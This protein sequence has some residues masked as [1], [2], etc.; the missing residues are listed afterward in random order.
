MIFGLFSSVFFLFGKDLDLLWNKFLQLTNDTE[1]IL[2]L[3]PLNHFITT[4]HLWNCL[5]LI[6][7][8]N[9]SLYLIKRARI[10]SGKLI[11][12][13][14]P[15]WKK[16]CWIKDWLLFK[17]LNQTS[18]VWFLFILKYLFEL[19]RTD[20]NI[21]SYFIFYILKSK[22]NSLAQY[23]IPKPNFI[24]PT[25]S[26]LLRFSF[27]HTFL[28][29]LLLFLFLTQVRSVAAIFCCTRIKHLDLYMSLAL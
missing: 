4:S 21:S 5:A 3:I 11:N 29:F 26:L 13:V 27:S 22:P 16:P 20:Y 2:Q 15:S 25:F 18:L 14:E 23:Q 7:R 8:S 6:K 9:E 19:N 12:R 24:S 28:S 17:K 1:F 10:E